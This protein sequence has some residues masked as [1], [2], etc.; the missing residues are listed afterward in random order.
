MSYAADGLQ[1][2]EDVSRWLT[3]LGEDYVAYVKQFED[4]IVDGFWLL[5]YVNDEILIQYEVRNPYHRRRILE[6]I[7]E[8]KKEC[9]RKRSAK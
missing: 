9:Q 1:S 3:A 2:C 7:E 5:N 8:K 6:A 4:K